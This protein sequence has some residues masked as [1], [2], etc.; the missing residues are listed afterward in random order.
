MGRHVILEHAMCFAEYLSVS[1]I[2]MCQGSTRPL[3]IVG[4]PGG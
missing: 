3:S 2:S 4:T 1:S